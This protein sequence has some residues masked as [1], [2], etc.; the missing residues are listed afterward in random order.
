MCKQIRTGPSCLILGLTK[1]QFFTKAGCFIWTLI[2]IS[3][4]VTITINMLGYILSFFNFPMQVVA[5]M[6]FVS[7]MTLFSLCPVAIYLVGNSAEDI[8]NSKDLAYPQ[9][10]Y[11]LLFAV[12]SE[13]ILYAANIYGYWTD[14]QQLLTL[15]LEMFN[16]LLS[17]QLSVVI[18]SMTSSLAKRCTKLSFDQENNLVENG[19]KLL[20]DFRGLKEGSQ[21]G[22][23]IVIVFQTTL[24][25]LKV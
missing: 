21:M 23:L 11:L 5:V 17:V 1:L 25:V 4:Q 16:F 9:Y 10:W 14:L 6:T 8:L 18:G 2:L 22:M 19:K 13:F 12:I 20:K 24:L 15:I 3:A 7:K